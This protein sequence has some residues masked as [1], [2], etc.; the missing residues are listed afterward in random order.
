MM[1]CVQC[2]TPP[3]NTPTR[4]SHVLVYNQV[5]ATATHA[6]ATLLVRICDSATDLVL[7]S[8]YIECSVHPK[9]H[10]IQRDSEVSTF[11]T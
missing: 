9:G 1:R 7:L 10:I 6:L 4:Y 2:H 8:I 3:T 5:C 11:I